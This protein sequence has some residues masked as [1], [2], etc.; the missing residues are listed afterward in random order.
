MQTRRLLM[1]IWRVV[2]AVGVCIGVA[3]VAFKL[4]RSEPIL[5]ANVTGWNCEAFITQTKHDLPPGTPRA[6]VQAYLDE[7]KFPYEYVDPDLS[8]DPKGP[9]FYSDLYKIGRFL[10]IFDENLVVRIHLDE[11]N[12]LREIVFRVDVDAP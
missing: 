8:Y 11:Q 9:A 10:L 7:R 1:K 2:S 6:I 12:R 4:T 5:P 3:A